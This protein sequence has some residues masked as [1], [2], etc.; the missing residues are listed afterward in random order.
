MKKFS[1]IK[2]QNK[3]NLVSVIMNCYN[4]ERYISHAINSLIDQSHK[5]W[6]LIFFDNFSNDGSVKILEKFKDKRIKYFKSKKKLKLGTARQEAISKIKGDYVAFLDTDDEWYSNKL[7]D[8]IKGFKDKRIGFVI[9]NTIFFNKNNQK[10]LYKPNTKFEK[11]VFYDLIKK[12]FIS[13]D[14]VI[15]KKYF[16]NKLDKKFD[17]KFDIIHDMDLLIRLSQICEMKYIPKILSK[18]RM[19]DDSLSYNNFNILIK[20]KKIFIKEL[21]K[22]NILDKSFQDSK[23]SYLDI[24][25]RQEILCLLSQKKIRKTFKLIKKLNFN[26]KNLLLIFLIFFPFKKIIFKKLLNL[27]Y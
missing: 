26:F 24:L 1:N 22:K 20:E 23:K 4:G 17:K 12:Y 6:E 11:K 27:K 21:S 16:L 15:I 18:W 13:F 5:N 25:Y 19:S 14:T 9:S 7:S 3:N 2:R 10:A 8:Q